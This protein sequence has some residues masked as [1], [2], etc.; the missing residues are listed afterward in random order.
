MSLNDGVD[1]LTGQVVSWETRVTIAMMELGFSL[2]EIET[3]KVTVGAYISQITIAAKNSTKDLL[4]QFRKNWKQFKNL[5][6]ATP[7]EVVEAIV[8][9]VEYTYMA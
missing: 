6:D 2:T 9:A 5:N 7:E 4:E 3:F 1:S 8:K